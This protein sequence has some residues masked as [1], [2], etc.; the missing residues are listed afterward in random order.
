MHDETLG[1]DVF[2]H[3]EF[4]SMCGPKFCS[5]QISRH[6]GEERPAQPVQ[7]GD[8]KPAGKRK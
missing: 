1:H 3:A 2:K 8:A 7:L 6:L 5:M 4:C